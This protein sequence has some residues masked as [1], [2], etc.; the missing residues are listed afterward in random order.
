MWLEFDQ[1]KLNKNQ[2]EFIPV[3]SEHFSI[4]YALNNNQ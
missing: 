3:D 2:T 1:K 4:W